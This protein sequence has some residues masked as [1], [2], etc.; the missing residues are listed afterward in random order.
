MVPA[1]ML[2]SKNA[3]GLILQGNFPAYW[4]NLTP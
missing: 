1:I 4:W 2:I 3:Q